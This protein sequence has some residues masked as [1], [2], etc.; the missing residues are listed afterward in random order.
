MDSLKNG[1]ILLHILFDHRI[2]TEA[3]YGSLNHIFI[4][5]SLLSGRGD[6]IRHKFVAFTPWVFYPKQGLF[7]LNLVDS[8]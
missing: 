2:R 5:I 6:M 7:I 4:I 3:I 1:V 8:R